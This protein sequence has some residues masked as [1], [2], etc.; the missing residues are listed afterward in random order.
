MKQHDHHKRESW[1]PKTWEALRRRP[2]TTRA[3]FADVIVS[4]HGGYVA[5][6]D[7]MACDKSKQIPAA[8]L[9]QHDWVF[10]LSD[11]SDVINN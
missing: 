9:D 1:K 2:S 10:C 6:A 11:R 3:L 8:I 7:S 4:H 5:A